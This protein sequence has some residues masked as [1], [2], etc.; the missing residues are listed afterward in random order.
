MQKGILGKKLGM[1]QLFD[2]KGN[3]VPVTVIEAGPCVVSQKKTVENDG[4]AAIQVGYGDLKA[5][6]VNKPMK[7]HFAKGDVAPKKVLREFRLENTDTYNVGDI[8]KADV[9]AEGDKID[10]VGTSKGKGTAGAIKRWNFSRLRETHG[11]GPVGRHAG[12]LGACSSPSRVFKGKKLAGHLG[13]ERVTVQNL[14]VVKVDT[15]NNIIAV[16]GA[17]PGPKGGIVMIADSVKA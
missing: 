11:T 5:N 3:V 13:S 12:S 14:T 4:Y 6:K 15:E 16:K 8:I 17:V 2:E 10:V 7:G 1:T 9:F